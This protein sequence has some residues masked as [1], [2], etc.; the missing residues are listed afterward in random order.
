MSNRSLSP[1]MSEAESL[2]DDIELVEMTIRT[3]SPG[4]E[5]PSVI[6]RI[7][8][9]ISRLSRY[10][11]DVDA[12]EGLYEYIEKRMAHI[13]RYMSPPIRNDEGWQTIKADLLFNIELA[14]EKLASH[15]STAAVRLTGIRQWAIDRSWIS[16][17]SSLPPTPPD[18]SL[19]CG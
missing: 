18:T 2:L 6:A 3:G 15:E 8:E 12:S 5:W 10:C 14:G 4:H 9:R 16:V 7:E 19:R 13:E 17:E 11:T 1:W